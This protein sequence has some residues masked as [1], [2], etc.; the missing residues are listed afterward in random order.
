MPENSPSPYI[1]VIPTAPQEILE[2]LRSIPERFSP[3][4]ITILS[5]KGILRV[6]RVLQGFQRFLLAIKGIPEYLEKFPEHEK[7]FNVSKDWLDWIIQGLE[8]CI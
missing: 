5:C 8:M 4:I 2:K 3:T 6:P 7:Y 1:K